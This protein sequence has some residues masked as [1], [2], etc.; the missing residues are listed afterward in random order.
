MEDRLKKLAKSVSETDSPV[1]VFL[2]DVRVDLGDGSSVDVEG[3]LSIKP[4]DDDGGVEEVIEELGDGY[5][6]RSG[7]VK[8]HCSDKETCRVELVEEDRVVMDVRRASL[9]KDFLSSMRGGGGEDE[10]NLLSSLA[11]KGFTL[12]VKYKGMTLL[13]NADPESLMSFMKKL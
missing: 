12:K 9:F 8:L 13:R 6:V 5:E 10:G 3:T 11:E 1:E 4:G 2:D 7:G